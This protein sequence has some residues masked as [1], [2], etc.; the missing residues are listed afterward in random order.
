MKYMFC[1]SFFVQQYIKVHHE[2]A[3]GNAVTVSI[4]IKQGNEPDSFKA[5]FPSWDDDH[6]AV[7]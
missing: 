1:S 3:G 7:S 5:L 2:R 6:W 4:V